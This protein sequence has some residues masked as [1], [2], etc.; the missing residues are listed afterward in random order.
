M[1]NRN[2]SIALL[3]FAIGVGVVV[4]GNAEARAGL[5]PHCVNSAT[6]GDGIVFDELKV[7]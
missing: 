4:L 2:R 1:T 5:C 6:V 7:A 3:S